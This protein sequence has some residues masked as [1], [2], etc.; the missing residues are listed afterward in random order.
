MK[1]LQIIPHYLPAER[2][3]GPQKVAHS[4]GKSFVKDGHEVVVC[5]TNLLNERCQL[6]VPVD[7]PIEV[8]GVK[9][10][11]EKTFA[12][13]YW[14]F[15]PILW[16]RIAIEM[17]K[18]DV[19]L[20]H[21]HY[22]FANWIGARLARKM[23]KPYIIFAHGSLHR[24]GIKNNNSIIK[25]L[26][27]SALETKN[28]KQALFIAFNAPEELD[29]S[30]FSEIG[31]VIPSGIDPHEFN[32]DLHKS[33]NKKNNLEKVNKFTF[34]YLGRLD[35]QQKGLDFLINVFAKSLEY[36][37]DLFLVL[38][39]PD[40]NGAREK[41]QTQINKRGIQN[42]IEFTGLITGK[43]KF[44]LLQE[45]DCF[46]LPSRFEGLSIAL[47][48]ALYLK[49][50]VITSDQVGLCGQIKDVSCGDVIPIN[51]DLWVAGILRMAQNPLA[52]LMGERSH[53]LVL[54]NYSWDV[55]A[56][57]LIKQIQELI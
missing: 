51:E 35:I 25:R 45:A 3:G 40:E 26:Y 19:V 12:L 9:V 52:K 20:V 42:S 2:F 47:L 27:L 16:R 50:P 56:R 11:Y 14:G 13:H 8:D 46:I 1:I 21:S 6:D 37:P 48:E 43:E 18:V 39:G 53:E 36:N 10:F 31:R 54:D 41:L 17:Q 5:T 49:L 23:G 15:S 29:N 38:A 24:Q 32:V 7:H 28:F 34:V 33:R 30:L 4:L 22:Q 55:I 57:S 44:S